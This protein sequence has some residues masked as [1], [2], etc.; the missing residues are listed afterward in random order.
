LKP[1]GLRK[2]LS[3]RRGRSYDTGELEY[4]TWP[5][6]SLA[7][8]KVAISLIRERHEAVMRKYTSARA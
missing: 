6:A 3:L 8:A 7:D 2:W 1:R 4:R 5:T